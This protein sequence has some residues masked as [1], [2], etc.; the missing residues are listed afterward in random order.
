[1]SRERSRPWQDPTPLLGFLPEWEGQFDTFQDWVNHASRALTGFK[2][3]MGEEIKAICVDAKGR[4]CHCGADF[5]RARD[6]NA[7]P[8]RYFVTGTTINEAFGDIGL[9]IGG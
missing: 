5:M 9:A 7:F 8:I 2:G 3:T 6:D 4:R 1:M